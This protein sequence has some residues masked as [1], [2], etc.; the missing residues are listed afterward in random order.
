[1]WDCRGEARQAGGASGSESFAGARP[2]PV[3]GEKQPSRRR[4]AYAHMSGFEYKKQ[5]IEIQEKLLIKG[6]LG[7]AVFETS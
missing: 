3:S 1:L 2:E 4:L 7:A 6:G 5:W